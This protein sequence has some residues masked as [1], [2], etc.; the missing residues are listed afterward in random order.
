MQLKKLLP[1]RIILSLYLIHVELTHN[2][3]NFRQEWC[4]GMGLTILQHSLKQLLLTA[5]KSAVVTASTRAVEWYKSHAHTSQI[6][7]HA[8]QIR[9]KV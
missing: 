4:M 1:D 7:S 5:S 6:Q 3:N 9:C 8:V 2:L